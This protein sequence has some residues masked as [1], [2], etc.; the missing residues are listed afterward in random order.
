MGYT[1]NNHHAQ[2]YDATKA[3][4]KDLTASARL[5]YLENSEHDKHAARMYGDPA[6]KMHGSMKGDQSDQHIDYKNYK[7]T[8]KGYHGSTGSSHG[9]QSNIFHDYEKHPS[10]MYGDPAAKNITKVL[11]EGA[12]HNAAPKMY[13][14]AAP[15]FNAGLRAA[16]AA[17]K[18]S[19]K[20]EDAVNAAPKM[21]ADLSDIPL[22][23]D[24]LSNRM[25]GYAG[26]ASGAPDPTRPNTSNDPAPM[27]EALGKPAL[28]MK[29]GI[30][31]MCGMKK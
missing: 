20:F 27:M 17:G 19:G 14:D 26:D 15:K 6:A 25:G 1:G 28:M 18:L 22:Q 10:K 3:Y 2:K 23:K 29:K 30:A 13:D 12:K 4:D 11:S 16:S 7:G 5:H 21:D 9:D 24:L 31:S 8:D